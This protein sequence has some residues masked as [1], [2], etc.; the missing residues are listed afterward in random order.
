MLCTIKK[1]NGRTDTENQNHLS[2]CLYKFAVAFCF[3]ESPS[4]PLCSLH[5]TI[6]IKT[7]LLFLIS[8]IYFSSWLMGWLHPSNLSVSVKTLP[9]TASWCSLNDATFHSSIIVF[10]CTSVLLCGA[11]SLL[12]LLRQDSS[13][14]SDIFVWAGSLHTGDIIFF[15][16]WKTKRETVFSFP[17][18]EMHWKAQNIIKC[19]L[20]KSFVQT[21]Y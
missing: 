6:P 8:K 20:Q 19:L 1:N 3:V 13:N 18:K 10:G 4:G 17:L 15:H 11:L 9:D 12:F 21:H 5:C 14:A 2:G 7:G 16:Y